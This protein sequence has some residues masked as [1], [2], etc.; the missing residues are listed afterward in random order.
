MKKFLVLLLG[1]LVAQNCT[2][3]RDYTKIQVQEA[4]HAQKYNNVDRHFKNYD[5]NQYFINRTTSVYD[6]KI[7][8]LGIKYSVINNNDYNERLQQD[9]EKLSFAEKCTQRLTSAANNV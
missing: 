7:I 6:P 1:I 4:K 9:E 2:I 5:T 3:A 8:D